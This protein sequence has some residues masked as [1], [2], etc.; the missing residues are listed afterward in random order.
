LTEFSEDEMR[1]PTPYAVPYGLQALYTGSKTPRKED[2]PMRDLSRRKPSMTV[3]IDLGD[4][5]S[6]LCLV[7]TVKAAR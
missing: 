2:R 7:D 1:R 4:K 6:F 3:G 5:Y